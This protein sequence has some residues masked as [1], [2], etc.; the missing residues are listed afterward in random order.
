MISSHCGS[1]PA[2]SGT[3]GRCGLTPLF[4]GHVRSYGEVKLNFASYMG[5]GCTDLGGLGMAD[6]GA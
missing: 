2:R 1:P 5:I 3:A 4:W 6:G